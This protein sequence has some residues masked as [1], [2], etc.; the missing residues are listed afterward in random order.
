LVETL[1]WTLFWVSV[2]VSVVVIAMM[3]WAAFF[4]R[5]ADT[6]VKPDSGGRLV[7][8]LGVAIPAAIL[9]GT[10]GL[11]VGS[12]ARSADP[13]VPAR[14]SVEVVGH[15][16]WWEVRYPDAGVVTANEIHVPADA[17]VELRLSTADVIHS[18]WV[19]ELMP[20]VDLIPG[21]VN[22]T[23]FSADRPGE[24]RGQCAEYCGLQHGHM[25][26]SVVAQPA[27]QFRSWLDRQSRSAAV[28]DTAEERRGREVFE[29]SPCATCHTVRGTSAD[30]QKGPDLTH[31]GGRDRL[32]A[33]AVPNTVG[34]MSG[35]VSNSQSIKP[36]NLMP[37]Q[38]L[39]PGELRAVVTYL[40]SLE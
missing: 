35:W 24:Y 15:R 3:L 2:V 9:V 30:G 10:F 22:E 20:K 25:A 32:A 29:T 17:P 13:P 39:S 7:L 12:I 28:P 33:G 11:S 26:F 34:Y 37:P 36:G 31:V 23:W 21:R 1:W 19:P 18:F 8:V 40:Q 5:R 14:L 38:Q 6:K 16:W 4:R 27:A